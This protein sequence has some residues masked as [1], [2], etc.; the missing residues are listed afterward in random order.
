MTILQ[1]NT[2]GEFQAEMNDIIMGENADVNHMPVPGSIPRPTTGDEVQDIMEEAKKVFKAWSPNPDITEEELDRMRSE[3]KDKI[4]TARV[5]LLLRYPFFGNM[6]TRLIIEEGDDWCPTAATDGR[7]MYY[8]VQFFYKMN[9]DETM[10]VIAH[11]ILHCVYDHIGR[12][13]DRNPKLHNIAADYKVNNTLVHERCGKMP[14]FVQGYQDFKYNDWTSEEIYDELFKEFE[15]S[16]EDLEALG[17]LLDE[18]VDWGDTEGEETNSASGGAQG[19][20]SKKKGPPRKYSKEEL[21][22][23]RDEIKDSMLQSAQAAGA[24]NVP[25]DVARLIKELTEPKMNWQDFVEQQIQSTIR[26]DYTFIRPSRKSWQSGAILPGM[27]FAQTIDV[28]L[29]LDMSGSIGDL[30]ARDM[31]SEVHGMMQQYSE[32]RIQI[33]CFDTKVYN[34]D[35]FTHDDGRDITEYNIKGG[36]GTDFECNWEYMK[37]NDIQPK[38]FIMF[39]DGYPFGSWGDPEYCDTLFVIHSHHDKNLKAPFGM[40]THYANN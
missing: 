31:I 17:E 18:H 28:A 33:W 25:G 19:K 9:I 12:R 34:Y 35:V 30:Q 39:T 8:N 4:I 1:A 21:R 14:H 16:L 29:G 23:I 15:N 26:D 36:G 38:K 13:E 24:G 5:K 40:T 20:A 11:E 10:F 2:E 7:Y 37:E 32:Y 6:A 27:N 3:V 22:K